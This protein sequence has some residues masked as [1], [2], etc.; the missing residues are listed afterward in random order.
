MLFSFSY[1][2]SPYT[3]RLTKIHKNHKN[4]VLP[5]LTAVK[6]PSPPANSLSAQHLRF[7]TGGWMSYRTNILP[8]P[9]SCLNRDRVGLHWSGLKHKHRFQSL[10]IWK[11]TTALIS[12]VSELSLPPRS[13]PTF[14]SHHF[15]ALG[16]SSSELLLPVAMERISLVKLGRSTGEKRDQGASDTSA[17]SHRRGENTEQTP[18]PPV[19][20]HRTDHTDHRKNF[21]FSP[22]KRS[23]FWLQVSQA[24]SNHTTLTWKSIFSKVELGWF[25]FPDRESLQKLLN[26]KTSC[27]LYTM[28]WEQSTPWRRCPLLHFPSLWKLCLFT[29]LKLPPILVWF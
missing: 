13:S 19:T 25:C 7:W 2:Q 14:L 15:P 21:Q 16:L 4:P 24:K 20:L 17:A 5:C 22:Q 26:I 8:E 6:H 18:I 12:L 11:F 10:L 28:S 27:Q 23:K 9:W 1:I 29:A 3:C